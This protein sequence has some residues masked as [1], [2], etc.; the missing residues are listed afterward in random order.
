MFHVNSA[1]Y[2]NGINLVKQI[3]EE[4]EFCTRVNISDIY[5][6]QDKV[7]VIDSR[8]LGSIYR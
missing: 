8:E 5:L 7:W 3:A 4:N 1:R 2:Q 6:D